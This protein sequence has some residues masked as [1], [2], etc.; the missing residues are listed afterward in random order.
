MSPYSEL[1]PHHLLSLTTL[2]GSENHFPL[3]K[4][5]FPKLK[6]FFCQFYQSVS[7]SDS[8][9]KGMNFENMREVFVQNKDE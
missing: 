6:P 7:E 4:T 9:K 2:G 5:T 8:M 3:S 1:V